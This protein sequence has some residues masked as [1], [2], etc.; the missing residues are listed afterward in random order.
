MNS[1]QQTLQSSTFDIRILATNHLSRQPQVSRSGCPC[2]AICHLYCNDHIDNQ[3]PSIDSQ[4]VRVYL[5]RFLLSYR[6][7]YFWHFQ[8]KRRNESH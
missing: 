2:T 5:L 8:H 1:L 3:H 4:C 7:R 6:H